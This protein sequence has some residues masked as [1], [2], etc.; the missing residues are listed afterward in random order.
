[1]KKLL[2]V[3]LAAQMSW[4]DCP[5]ALQACEDV[6]VA[7]DQAIDNLK[8][9]V[10]LLKEEVEKEKRTTPAWVLIVGGMALG[11]VSYSLTRK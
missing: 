5:K 4:G 6:I 11:I 3:I 8:K 1:M 9:Q 10:I 7:Q 2:C